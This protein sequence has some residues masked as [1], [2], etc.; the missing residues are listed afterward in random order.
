MPPEFAYLRDI[1]P[2]IVQEMRYATAFNFTGAPVPGYANAECVLLR[3]AAEA[4]AKV[5]ADLK[6]KGFGLKVYDCF[7]PIRAVNAFVRWSAAKDGAG[8]AAFYPKLAKEQLFGLGYIARHSGHSKGAAVDLG[9]VQLGSEAAAGP[10]RSMTDC[11]G[12]PATRLS[13][14]E[15]DM[16]TS[17]DCF[18]ARSWTASTEVLSVQYGNRM[19][20]KAAMEG[21]G[22]RNY[23][24]EWWHY[25]FK[26]VSAGRAYDFSPARNR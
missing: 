5:Q 16:G 1:D 7:R 9:L 26:G 17:F 20:L 10:N 22:F 8:N 18:D 6:S 14:S 23:A 4:L 21:R 19:L 13:P 15:V 3:T 12:L 2:S 11:A 25:D 24:R